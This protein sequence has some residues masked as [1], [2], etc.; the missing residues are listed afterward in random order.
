[1]SLLQV[2]LLQQVNLDY[3][4]GN[5]WA[6]CWPNLKQLTL[7]CQ[8]CVSR[9]QVTIPLQVNLD[10]LDEN[11]LGKVLAYFG[12]TYSKLFRCPG[13]LTASHPTTVVQ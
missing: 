7:N 13:V 3:L 2:T 11:R 4:N 8:G 9:L 12:T 1:M 5:E 10:Y 6:K